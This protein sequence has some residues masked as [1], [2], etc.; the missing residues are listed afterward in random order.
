MEIVKLVTDEEGEAIC[1]QEYK[2]HGHKCTMSFSEVPFT[3][4]AKVDE[5]QIELR[6]ARTIDSPSWGYIVKIKVP[7]EVSPFGDV[8]YG[9]RGHYDSYTDA[10]NAGVAHAEYSEAEY[11]RKRAQRE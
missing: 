9:G 3:P 6:L 11:Q 8:Q 7:L 4:V 1:R 5:Y 10:L 2:V